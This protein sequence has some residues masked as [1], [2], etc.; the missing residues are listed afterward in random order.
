MPF[1]QG[2]PTCQFFLRP[3][4]KNEGKKS[5]SLVFELSGRNPDGV[6]KSGDG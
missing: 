4:F 5:A 2:F 6:R 1:K 3:H